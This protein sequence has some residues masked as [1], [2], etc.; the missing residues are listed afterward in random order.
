MNGVGDLAG[1]DPR[2]NNWTNGCRRNG[3]RAQE[4]EATSQFEPNL[5]AAEELSLLLQERVRSSGS[6]EKK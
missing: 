1:A 4:V 2:V 6:F 5:N 3:C